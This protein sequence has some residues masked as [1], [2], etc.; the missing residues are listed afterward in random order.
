MTATSMRPLK[1]TFVR[2]LRMHLR[3]VRSGEGT[4]WRGGTEGRP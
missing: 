1:P 3:A 4:M 2:A